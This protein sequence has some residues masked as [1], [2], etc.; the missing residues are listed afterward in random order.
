MTQEKALE[1]YKEA[2]TMMRFNESMRH[3]EEKERRR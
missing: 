1:D 3:S 2:S